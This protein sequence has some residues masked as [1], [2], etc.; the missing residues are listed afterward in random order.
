[1]SYNDFGRKRTGGIET[2]RFNFDPFSPSLVQ[3]F[4]HLDYPF[5]CRNEAFKKKGDGIDAF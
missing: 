5:Y 3:Y 4:N 2:R 1:M